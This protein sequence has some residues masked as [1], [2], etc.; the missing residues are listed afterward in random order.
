MFFMKG[1]NFL[2]FFLMVTVLCGCS[3][4]KHLAPTEVEKTDLESLYE[5]QNFE[6]IVEITQRQDISKMDCRSLEIAALSY[7]KK[8]VYQKAIEVYDTFLA[9]CP[10]SPKNK[11]EIDIVRANIYANLTEWD[12]AD[13]LYKKLRNFIP[14]HLSDTT[15]ELGKLFYYHGKML[16]NANRLEESEELLIKSLVYNIEIEENL[17]YLAR[18]YATLSKLFF[19]MGNMMYSISYLYRAVDA[20]MASQNYM[21]ALNFIHKKMNF[22]ASKSLS[23]SRFVPVFQTI[24]KFESSFSLSEYVF[25]K[26]L[27][28]KYINKSGSEPLNNAY[29]IYLELDSI[30]S[31]NK[32]VFL[33]YASLYFEVFFPILNRLGKIEQSRRLME[34]ISSDFALQTD[35]LLASET[36]NMAFWAYNTGQFALSQRLFNQA[37]REY[38]RKYGKNSPVTAELMDKIGVMYL[39]S[40]LTIE[41]RSFFSRSLDIKQATIP[42]N[43]LD[44]GI[45]Y[46]NMAEVYR[47]DGFHDRAIELYR[48]AIQSFNSIEDESKYEWLSRV[49]HNLGVLYTASKDYDSSEYYLAKAIDKRVEVF[50][51]TSVKLIMPY[52]AAGK[53]FQEN[54]MFDESMRYYEKASTIIQVNGLHN[55]NFELSYRIGR[56]IL[57]TQMGMLD[58]AFEYLSF[59]ENY[60]ASM[61]D[62]QTERLRDVKKYLFIVAKEREDANEI[63]RLRKAIHGY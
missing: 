4:R 59:A 30:Y 1:K 58:K 54:K 18:G 60:L 41:A 23:F 56:G 22:Y 34:T 51:K 8:G 53:L 45:S 37:L 31:Q 40:G 52:I 26:I 36:V 28:A 47:I 42:D 48:K 62:W 9:R 46:N 27:Y 57:Y 32:S 20:F 12:K 11:Y 63:R 2:V 16:Y 17:S 44:M 33:N 29:L 43:N 39:S 35:T 61:G 10:H 3:L 55:T 49:Y 38:Q 5:Q 19:L 24:A 13:S 15:K 7:Y 6:Q 25:Y 21:E 50:G 14:K